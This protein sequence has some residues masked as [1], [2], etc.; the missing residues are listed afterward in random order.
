MRLGLNGLEMVFIFVNVVEFFGRTYYRLILPF[1]SSP[2]VG[3]TSEV[4]TNM[5]SGEY[6]L[7]YLEW[8]HCRLSQILSTS[9]GYGCLKFSVKLLF[10]KHKAL[11]VHVNPSSFTPFNS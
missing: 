1:S 3:C 10:A 7:N 2:E 5:K 8:S 6:E 11:P 4:G 9:C